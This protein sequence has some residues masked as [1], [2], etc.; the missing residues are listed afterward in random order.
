MNKLKKDYNFEYTPVAELTGNAAIY[1]RVPKSVIT[2]TNL[3]NIRLAIFAYLSIY[4]G[5][6]NRVCFSIPLFLKWAGYK[7]D[8]HSGGINDKVISTLDEFNK[9]GY[10]AYIN[11]KPHTRTACF[12][13]EFNTNKVNDVCFEESFAILYWDEV[14]RI[15]KYS[16][17][18]TQDKYLNRNTIL[19]VFAFL[20]QAIFRV[21]NKLKPE[22]RSSEG[23]A[24]RRERCIE[25]YNGSYKD[26]SESIGLSKRTVSLAVKILV[27]LKLIAVAEAYHTTNENG[28]YITPYL[29]FA[30]MEKREGKQLLVSGEDYAVNEI[31]KKEK[32]LIKFIP[33]YCIRNISISA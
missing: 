16:N 25:A 12:E 24:A 9:L 21:P 15:M 3:L 29:I 26:I 32:Y 20:R 13:M 11:G 10:V 17:T 28:Q 27:Q 8:S 31:R 33:N 30:N 14:E 7:N 22:E 18:N 23:V 4:R 5:L 2:D 6:N 19:L 1:F